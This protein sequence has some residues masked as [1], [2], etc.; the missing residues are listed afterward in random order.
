[1]PRGILCSLI[2]SEI[3]FCRNDTFLVV[4]TVAFGCLKSASCARYPAKYVRMPSFTNL[5]LMDY[6]FSSQ[7]MVRPRFD[8][9]ST[10]HACI[11]RLRVKPSSCVKPS[12]DLSSSWASRLPSE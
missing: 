6:S 5:Y 7:L 11:R 3:E 8:C 10:V 12:K 4:R 9:S 2:V 1:M